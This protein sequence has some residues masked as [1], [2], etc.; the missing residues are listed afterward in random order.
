MSDRFNPFPEL[1]EMF[2]DE[3]GL[4]KGRTFEALQDAFFAI[5][6]GKQASRRIL[7]NAGHCELVKK[8]GMRI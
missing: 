5:K 7:E 6:Q 8:H 3:P 2:S 1:S 4:L